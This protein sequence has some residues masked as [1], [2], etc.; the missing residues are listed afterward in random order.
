MSEEYEE[1]IVEE[2]GTAKSI[3]RRYLLQ[4]MGIAAGVTIFG[5]TGFA[6]GETKSS[7]IDEYRNEGRVIERALEEMDD[8]IRLNSEYILHVDTKQA[9]KDDISS[10]SQSIALTYSNLNNNI[11]YGKEKD[12]RQ[13]K[14]RNSAKIEEL[15]E[16]FEPYFMLI[17]SG[18]TTVAPSASKF[19]GSI[20]Q[21]SSITPQDGGCGGNRQDPH[22]CPS[23]NWSGYYRSQKSDVQNY[24]KD[25][26]Y[27]ETAAYAAYETDTDWTKCVSAYG[28]SGC[29]FRSQAI[30]RQRVGSWTYN[31]QRPEPT[32]EVL[33][34]V[35]PTW[36][37]GT[38]VEWW[39]SSFC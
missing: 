13:T 31:T 22:L 28:C 14:L 17:A 1:G 36:N 10:D 18:E 25:K 35:W 19:G 34:Y 38:Y 26:G 20:D 7:K 6:A 11:M 9:N 23:R 39:H 29:A 2:T 33:N 12:I 27:H 24:L 4:N 30:I 21:D 32:P 8:Y 5:F 37:W 16:D 15:L 3:N